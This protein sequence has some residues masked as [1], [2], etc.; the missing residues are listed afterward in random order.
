MYMHETLVQLQTRY[1]LITSPEKPLRTACHCIGQRRDFIV[2]VQV[3]LY[4]N[5]YTYLKESFRISERR[6]K[7]FPAITSLFLLFNFIKEI[8]KNHK[9]AKKFKVIRNYDYSE[10]IINSLIIYRE[11]FSQGSHLL[12]RSIET[13]KIVS[14]IRFS[15]KIRM[16]KR[17]FSY[18][19]IPNTKTN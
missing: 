10:F 19:L 4:K 18:E 17:I 8:K 11:K 7:S 2:Y 1:L 5:K 14:S 16:G 3:S 15:A 13:M 9:Q 12:V 6:S